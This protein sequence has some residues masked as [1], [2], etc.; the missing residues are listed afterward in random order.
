MAE[1]K[2]LTLAELSA[3]ITERVQALEDCAGTTVTVQYGL[4]SPDKDGC[5][6][7]DSVVFRP[8]P[9]A[10]KEVLVTAVGNVVREARQRFN[11]KD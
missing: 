9:N 6:W 2:L 10:S 5:N 1:R 3:W 4:R 11:I 8:G 7:S